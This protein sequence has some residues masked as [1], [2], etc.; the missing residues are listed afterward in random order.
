[1][2]AAANGQQISMTDSLNVR[3]LQHLFKQWA[4]PPFT[5][6]LNSQRD[7]PSRQEMKRVALA[8][9]DKEGEG[10][11]EDDKKIQRKNI[12]KRSLNLSEEFITWKH[13]KTFAVALCKTLQQL[14]GQA[15][16]TN[17]RGSTMRRQRSTANSQPE[18]P[19]GRASTHL[20]CSSTT[21]LNEPVQFT[22][23]KDPSKC[24][25]GS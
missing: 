11:I 5:L 12:L 13:I 21:D 1:M 10:E 23:T 16:S 14:Q 15:A 25:D 3:E 7:Q 24:A 18:T 2:I 9:S 19:R 4:Q 22:P 8:E 17:K 6:P 20:K